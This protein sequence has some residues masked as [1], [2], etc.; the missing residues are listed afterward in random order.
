MT[1]TDKKIFIGSLAFA[2]I[3]SLWWTMLGVLML[4]MMNMLLYLAVKFSHADVMMEPLARDE[5]L[6][7]YVKK[8]RKIT[9]ERLFE[10]EQGYLRLP[11][12]GA[13][14][15]VGHSDHTFYGKP[16]VII[17]EAIGHTVRLEYAKLAEW[18]E[19]AGIHSKEE[20][21]KVLNVD[22]AQIEGD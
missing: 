9:L 13:V 16:C 8:N 19:Q 3:M 2:L 14:K 5:I 7:I 1:I 15:T 10:R 18:L 12:W 20:L 6:G 17:G 21:A 11:T 4:V 22:L